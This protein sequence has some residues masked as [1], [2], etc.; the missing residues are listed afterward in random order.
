[1]GHRGHE[2]VPDESE[3]GAGTYEAS[4]ANSS[5][6]TFD[7]MAAHDIERAGVKMC[8]ALHPVAHDTATS[9][10]TDFVSGQWGDVAVDGADRI[11][12]ASRPHRIGGGIEAETYTDIPD[13][14]RQG[15][16]SATTPSLAPTPSPA[17]VRGK[18]QGNPANLGPEAGLRVRRVGFALAVALLR[19]RDPGFHV[20]IRQPRRGK[21]GFESV[22]AGS[23]RCESPF[24]LA[25]ATLPVC[26]LPSGVWKRHPRTGKIASATRIAD[27]RMRR[28]VLGNLMTDRSAGKLT[29]QHSRPSHP[30]R[31]E[32]RNEK[33]DVQQPG[34][35][36]R[37]HM[38]FIHTV[39]LAEDP[40]AKVLGKPRESFLP[41]S[42][43]HENV[44][45]LPGRQ[46]QPCVNPL[47][48]DAKLSRRV[49][50]RHGHRYG[51]SIDA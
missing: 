1:M 40:R 8:L 23:R 51:A 5:C 9:A 42:V 41:V 17:W 43:V 33:P 31:R 36:L 14:P 48:S 49:L 34:R 38:G 32:F 19:M 2:H 24:G 37:V 46:G 21:M 30:A 6:Y 12:W 15:S 35:R 7:L 20:S 4:S 18:A 13:P 44:P 26:E 22:R 47:K 10:A 16:S 29:R 27:L 11:A 45:V 39:C 28:T 50:D 25:I 3:G